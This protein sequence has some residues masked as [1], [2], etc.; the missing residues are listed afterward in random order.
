MPE[1]A[2]PTTPETV[3]PGLTA[4]VPWTRPPL[5]APPGEPVE[6]VPAAPAAPVMSKMTL[7]APAGAVVLKDPA[8][9]WVKSAMRPYPTML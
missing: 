8:V 1:P 3:S 5:P 2:L 9:V 4:I 7:T 6:P